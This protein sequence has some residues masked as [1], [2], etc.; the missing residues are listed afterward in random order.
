MPLTD[1]ERQFLGNVWRWDEIATPAVRDQY[2]GARQEDRESPFRTAAGP[3]AVL[4]D[5]QELLDDDNQL[6]RVTVAGLWTP[7]FKGKTDNITFRHPRF[8][9]TGRDMIVVDYRH[10][11]VR[12]RT[13]LLI[14]G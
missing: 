9:P 11:T 6:Y 3:A 10:D 12:S 2:P 5:I 8:A 4:G 7:T 13:T 14:Y 1:A